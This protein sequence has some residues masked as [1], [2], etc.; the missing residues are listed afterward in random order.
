MNM[1]SNTLSTIQQDPASVPLTLYNSSSSVSTFRTFLPAG[2]V[3]TSGDD[4]FSFKT[5]SSESKKYYATK[6]ITTVAGEKN[7][8]E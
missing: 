8:G 2:N 6:D 7:E 5:T 1:C 4:L 3:I